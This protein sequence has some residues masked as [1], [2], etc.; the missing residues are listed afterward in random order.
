M[1]HIHGSNHFLA[2]YGHATFRH[3]MEPYVSFL[4]YQRLSTQYLEPAVCGDVRREK[5]SP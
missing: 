5:Q 4:S 2:S 3:C 1:C